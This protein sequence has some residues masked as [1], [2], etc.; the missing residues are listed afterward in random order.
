MRIPWHP[1]QQPGIDRGFLLPGI[2]H[3]A[4]GTNVVVATFLQN[5]GRVT[6]LIEWSDM[7]PSAVKMEGGW[8]CCAAPFEGA[9]RRARIGSWWPVCPPGVIGTGKTNVEPRCQRRAVAYVAQRWRR[10]CECDQPTYSVLGQTGATNRYSD[11]GDERAAGRGAGERLTLAG[12]INRFNVV[13]GRAY[14]AAGSA[15][16]RFGMSTIRRPRSVW[17]ASTRPATRAL[18]ISWRWAVPFMRSWRTARTECKRGM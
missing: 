12:P 1:R 3:C 4:N 18:W 10:D 14:F 6:Y 2:D 7:K 11:Q 5:A 13:G 8:K 15:A 16:S 9:R 17:G